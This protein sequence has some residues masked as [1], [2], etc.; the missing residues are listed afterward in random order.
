MSS[1]PW[2]R[3]G[4][5]NACMLCDDRWS[6]LTRPGGLWAA[7]ANPPPP[8]GSERVRIAFEFFEIEELSQAPRIPPADRKDP[9]PPPQIRSKIG[10]KINQNFDA[11][12]VSFLVPLGP[13][14]GLLRPLGPGAAP[15]G[16]SWRLL[17]LGPSWGALGGSPGR[18]C[19]LLGGSWGALGGSKVALGRKARI[20]RV[21]R[22]SYFL[23]GLRGPSRGPLVASR[24]AQSG[25]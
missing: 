11:I 17:S 10:L 14:F 18:S 21:K 3:F 25:P 16:S 15:L 2:V 23:L 7:Q 24:A 9:G 12:L 13:H 5:L 6:L 4:A 19:H 8:E 1:A 22:F 20:R